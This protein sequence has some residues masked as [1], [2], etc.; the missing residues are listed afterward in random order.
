MDVKLLGLLHD[1]GHGPFS[2]LFERE[3]LPRVGAP[4]WSLSLS[5]M[6]GLIIQLLSHILTHVL[7]VII[8]LLD[9][10][11]GDRHVALFLRAELKTLVDFHGNEV[12]S[13]HFKLTVFL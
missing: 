13:L 1:I 4:T 12:S 10:T 6:L 7:G 3:F 8:Q 5:L 11:L 2:H 9:F